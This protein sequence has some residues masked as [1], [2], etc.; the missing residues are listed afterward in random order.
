MSASAE[1]P[2]LPCEFYGPLYI[3]GDPAPVSTIVEAKIGGAVYGRI[4]TTEQGAYGGP[5]T[6]DQRLKVVV[7]NSVLAQNSLIEFWIDGQKA[8]QSV[9][10][11]AGGST[12]MILS[13]GLPPGV[14][15]TPTVIETRSPTPTVVQTVTPMPVSTSIPGPTYTVP[16]DV[17]PTATN[18]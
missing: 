7:D 9:S 18:T 13:V 14:L 16:P 3:H 15:P 10:Y 12:Q 5:G 2:V 4:V 11:V 1:T 6:F 17:T 8:E